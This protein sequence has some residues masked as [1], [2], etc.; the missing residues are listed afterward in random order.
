M[1][2]RTKNVPRGGPDGGDG[3]RGGDV[4]IVAVPRRISLE[5]VRYVLFFFLFILFFL[6]SSRGGGNGKIQIRSMMRLDSILEE[7]KKS[8]LGFLFCFSFFK[9]IFLEKKN[10]RFFFLYFPHSPPP[11]TFL[12]LPSKEVQDALAKAVVGQEREEMMFGSRFP[13]ERSSER[14]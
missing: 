1:L 14:I 13:S 10:S 3:G 11:L 9:D 7:T 5:G 2:C 12:D 8:F 6:F 4:K